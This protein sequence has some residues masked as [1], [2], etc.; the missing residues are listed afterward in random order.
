MTDTR[1]SF[2]RELNAIAGS[3]L[4]PHQAA[5]ESAR[6]LQKWL[7]D[8][9]A[10]MFSEL[11]AEQPIF[12]PKGQGP[13]IVSRFD[14]VV[15]VANLN[16]VYSVRPY[17][18][19]MKRGNG[20]PNFI[21]GMDDS[22]EYDFNVSVLRLAIG[23]KD[24][25]RVRGLVA[26]SAARSIEAA[27]PTGKLEV[28]EFARPIPYELIGSYFGVPG[29]SIAQLQ[30]WTHKIFR[31]VFFNLTQDP[32]LS[33]EGTQAGKEFADYVDALVAAK[34]AELAS[35]A[36]PTDDTVIGRLVAMQRSPDTSCSDLGIRVNLTGCISGVADN[37]LGAVVNVLDVLLSHPDRLAEAAALARND[38]DAGLTEYVFEALRFAPAAPFLVRLAVE[39][40]VLAKGTP[41][42]TLVPAGSV[43]LA[44]TCSA[45]LDEQAID[46]PHEFRIGRPT[47]QNLQFGW[48]MHA[49]LGKHISTVQIMEI[50]KQVVRLPKLR[51][52]P[53]SAGR[54]RRDGPFPLELGVCFN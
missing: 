7:I 27:L 14:D 18:V 5:Q 24:L 50:V 49:C 35:Q 36:T 25:D 47:Y 10:E 20:G 9:P 34:K 26:A 15:E 46:N 40:H 28:V 32:N 8:K 33:A 13:V 11:R 42:A 44:A 22:A 3:G 43:V 23:R 17:S 45:M 6:V 30:E 19:A 38:D 51:R 41:R 39:D 21:L 53:G 48:G 37:T 52:A 31:D 16:G 12:V 54:P 4:P 2:V 29:P 1:E